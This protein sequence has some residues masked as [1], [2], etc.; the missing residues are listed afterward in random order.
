[1]SS[2]DIRQYLVLPG[3]RRGDGEFTRRYSAISGTP[4]RAPRRWWV[5]QE[6]FGKIWYSQESAEETVRSRDIRQDLVLPGERR[7]DG[8]YI[9]DKHVELPTDAKRTTVLF[10]IAT[11]SLLLNNYKTK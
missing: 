7:G 4:R 11:A 8:E 2:R 6:I 5:H 10:T 3:E 9:V 1:V